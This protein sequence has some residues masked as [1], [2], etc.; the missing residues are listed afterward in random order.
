MTIQAIKNLPLVLPK[1]LP[2]LV[3]NQESSVITK[4][5]ID[6][7]KDKRK[8]LKDPL[9]LGTTNF[10]VYPKS[11]DTNNYRVVLNPITNPT[12]IWKNHS[13]KELNQNFS[14]LL[15]IFCAVAILYNKQNAP[16]LANL[17]KLLFEIEKTNTSITISNK[18]TNSKFPTCKIAFTE[19]SE[20]AKTVTVVKKTTTFTVFPLGY[21]NTKETPGSSSST[22]TR[23]EHN[24]QEFTCY[25][26]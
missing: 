4:T 18:K 22:V 19:S 8:T 14:D 6:F 11:V 7:T 2:P 20:Q 12:G 15:N 10:F 5:I 1:I 23:N 17:L 21:Q 24:F 3:L 16:K 13:G 26:A 25:E 9:N